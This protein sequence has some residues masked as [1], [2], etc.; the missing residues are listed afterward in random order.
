MN[1]P[2]LSGAEQEET[3]QMNRPLLSEAEQKETGQMNR[4]LLSGGGTKR[5]RTDEPSPFV[6]SPPD[7][8]A[9][10]ER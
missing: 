10:G 7:S 4:P 2:L 6:P 8:D 1:R 9:G 5:N 3:R